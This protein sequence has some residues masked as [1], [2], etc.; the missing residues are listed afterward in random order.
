MMND[1]GKSDRSVVPGKPP[2]NADNHAAEVVEE[3][4]RAKGN[5]AKRDKLWTPSQT[6]LPSALARVGG[7]ARRIKNS[8]ILLRRCAPAVDPR[9]EPDMGNLYVRICAGGGEQSPSLP[10]HRRLLITQAQIR[11]V[12]CCCRLRTGLGGSNWIFR[13]ISVFGFEMQESSNFRFLLYPRDASFTISAAILSMPFPIFGE[14]CC[15]I[16]GT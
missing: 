1:R 10:R 15:S 4:D 9:Q 5:P 2:N 6:G 7:T 16:R 13:F 8:L 3:R 12:K 11:R 14:M